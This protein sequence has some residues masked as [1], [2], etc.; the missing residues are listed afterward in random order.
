[1]L[2]EIW[3]NILKFGVFQLEFLRILKAVAKFMYLYFRK[4]D[5]H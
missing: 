3:N 2:V 1:M 4:A 5:S